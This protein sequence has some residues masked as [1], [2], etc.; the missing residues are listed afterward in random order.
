VGFFL[1][2]GLIQGVC[3]ESGAELGSARPYGLQYGI[4]KNRTENQTVTK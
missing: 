1:Q 2:G 4:A 3:Y